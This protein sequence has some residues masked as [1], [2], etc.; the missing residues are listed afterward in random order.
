MTQQPFTEDFP[1]ADIHELMSPDL[2][3]QIIKGTFKDHIVTWVHEYLQTIHGETQANEII[4][5]IDRRYVTVVESMT[6]YIPDEPFPR[7]SLAPS[8]PGLRRF[9]DGRDFTQWTGDDSKAL[10]KVCI[11]IV[12]PPFLTVPSSGLSSSHRW[13]RP[14]RN[15]EVRSGTS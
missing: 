9:P 7:I 14:V 8:F 5:D 15:G 12:C 3:H 13:S 6:L 1:R 4:D 10:M 11:Q 2:L